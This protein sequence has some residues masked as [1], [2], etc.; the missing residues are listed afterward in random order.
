MIR[1]KIVSGG[2]S[3]ILLLSGCSQ[4]QKTEQRIRLDGIVHEHNVNGSFVRVIPTLFPA[5]ELSNHL[6]EYTILQEGFSPDYQEIF[7]GQPNVPQ[8]Y[9]PF[10]IANVGIIVPRSSVVGSPILR[11]MA[12]IDAYAVFEQL[13]ATEML[14]N[15][16]ITQTNNTH[17][18]I[19][20][21]P[22]QIT[23]ENLEKYLK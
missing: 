13:S 15:D 23:K 12:T 2:L 6:G 9:K 1:S 19:I 4:E 5:S 17:M 22:I 14:T 21:K 16:I 7:E 8:L 10:V 3:G 18:A 11:V 20:L